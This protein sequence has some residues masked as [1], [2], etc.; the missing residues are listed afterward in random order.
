[1]RF[2]AWRL[3][4]AYA[5]TC[6]WATVLSLGGSNAAAINLP[7]AGINA[8]GYSYYGTALPFVDVAHMSGKWRTQQPIQLTSTGYPASL[9]AGDMAQ[10]LI[11]TKNGGIYPPGQYTLQWQGSGNV[12]LSGPN[13]SVVSSQP[14][15]IVYQV[16]NPDPR[17]LVVQITQTDPTNPVQGITVKSPLNP[18]SSGIF[19]ADYEKDLASYGVIRYM[20]WNM[21]NNNSIANWSDRTTPA[22]AFW[23]GSSGVPY[24]YQIQLSNELKQDLWINVPAQATDDYVQNLAALV[25]QQLNPGLRVWVEYSNEVWNESFQQAQYADNVLKPEFGSPNS[26]QA[27]GRR[28]AQVFDIFSNQFSDPNRVVRVIAGQNAN[29]WV[30][31]N[32]LIGAT[33]NGVLKADVAAVAP[34]FNVDIDNLYNQYKQGSLSLD[35][36][37]ADLHSAVDTTITGSTQNLTV[38]AANNLPLVAYEGGQGLVAKP[39]TEHND[40]G[41]VALLT[42][43]NHDSRMGDLYTYLLDQWYAKGG[44]TFVFSGD[45]GPSNK[46]GSWALQE[47]Y[48]DTNAAKYKAVQDYLRVKMGADDFNRDGLVDSSDY[49][50]WKATDGA[51]NYLNADANGDGIIDASDYVLWRKAADSQFPLGLIPVMIPEPRTLAFAIGAISLSVIDRRYLARQRGSIGHEIWFDSRYENSHP[52]TTGEAIKR[53]QPVPQSAR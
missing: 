27:Y 11:F 48:L 50:V 20:G 45:V 4:Y 1:M 12:Q 8:M 49:N 53:S 36:V 43:I 5:L 41:F 40:Q 28:A 35:S 44:K 47:N 23:G 6:A 19:N 34:Y 7:V 13:L 51:S 42:Q 21:T 14:Q 32:A 52:R 30:L 16:T 17:G 38:A 25:K 18:S 33:E 3:W 39:G 22:S 9:G 46:W 24:E 26:S 2:K 29:A 10:G 37:F 31:K 15:K